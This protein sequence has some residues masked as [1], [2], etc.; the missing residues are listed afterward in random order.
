M[1]LTCYVFWQHGCC[2]RRISPKSKQFSTT[3]WG[4]FQ[5]RVHAA[6][7]VNILCV[8]GQNILNV[9]SIYKADVTSRYVNSIYRLNRISSEL[10]DKPSKLLPYMWASVQLIFVSEHACC[11]SYA[12]AAGWGR[13]VAKLSVLVQYAH[14][15]IY[16]QTERGIADEMLRDDQPD[17][18]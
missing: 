16:I 12:V 11:C 6:F 10:L 1:G 18:E 13:V 14:H 17:G 5:T 4:I 9:K 15:S 7:M 3:I 8:W 2:N